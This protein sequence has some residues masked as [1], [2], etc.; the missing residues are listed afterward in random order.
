[1]FY[2]GY[3]AICYVSIRT[4]GTRMVANWTRKLCPLFALV[5]LGFSQISTAAL[6]CQQSEGTKRGVNISYSDTNE[7]SR[8]EFTPAEDNEQWIGIIFEFFGTAPT[9]TLLQ[10]VSPSARGKDLSEQFTRA[11]KTHLEEQMPYDEIS[12]IRFHKLDGRVVSSF[13]TVFGD[14]RELL[15]I[16]GQ[17][18]GEDFQF[19]RAAVPVDGSYERSKETAPEAMHQMIRNCLNSG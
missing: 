10:D 14:H 19:F 4:K 3:L 2:G 13:D 16:Y 18:D 9:N 15:A 7:Y 12:D 8:F 1:M 6:T 17:W 5:C 11:F